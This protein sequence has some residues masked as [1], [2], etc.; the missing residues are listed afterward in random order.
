MTAGKE[1]GITWLILIGI[2]IV[3]LFILCDGIKKKSIPSYK[4]ECIEGYSFIIDRNG[5]IIQIFELD[6]QAVT[7]EEK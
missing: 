7:C 6:H 1:I 3:L 4:V 5:N 2:G